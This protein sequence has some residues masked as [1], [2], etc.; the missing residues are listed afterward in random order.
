MIV[1]TAIAVDFETVERG[2][3]TSDA[4]MTVTSTSGLEIEIENTTGTLEKET[5]AATET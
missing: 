2:P 4:E 5:I 3:G 1:G